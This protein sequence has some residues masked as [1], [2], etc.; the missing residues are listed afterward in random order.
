MKHKQDAIANANEL[1]KK[2]MENGLSKT[3]AE[4]AALVT[5]INGLDLMWN[6]GYT[7]SLYQRTYNYFVEILIPTPIENRINFSS[8]II[9]PVVD[10]E[11]DPDYNN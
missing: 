1:I 7:K 2:H 8:K 9:N 6:T 5:I 11:G 3:D 4:K 10:F